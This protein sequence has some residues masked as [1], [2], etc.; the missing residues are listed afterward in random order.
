MPSQI[1]SCRL[2]LVFLYEFDGMIGKFG[3]AQTSNAEVL[4]QVK[5]SKTGKS[6][7]RR[8]LQEHLHDTRSLRIAVL[9]MDRDRIA[10]KGA[11]EYET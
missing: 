10:V 4:L 3:C 9:K 5:I 11:T 6:L 8:L 2:D 7:R 1:W